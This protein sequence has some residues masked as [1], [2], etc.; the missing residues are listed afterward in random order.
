MNPDKILQA[1]KISLAHKKS[2]IRPSAMVKQAK[3]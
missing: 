2:W 3:K 1:A